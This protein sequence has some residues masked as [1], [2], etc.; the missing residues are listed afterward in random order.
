MG[1]AQ[2]QQAV[3]LFTMKDS[4]VAKSAMIIATIFSSILI[5][6][7]IPSAMIGRI[8]LEPGAISNP[9]A[10]MPVLTQRVLGPALSGV[11]ESESIINSWNKLK[12]LVGGGVRTL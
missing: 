10:L 11:N 2:P 3:A 5:W 7:L 12:K 6:C 4:K 9:D 8:I 1:V